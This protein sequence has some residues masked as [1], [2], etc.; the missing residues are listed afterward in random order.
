M[1]LLKLFYR[2]LYNIGKHHPPRCIDQRIGLGMGGV[3]Y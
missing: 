3:I 2:K 1:I